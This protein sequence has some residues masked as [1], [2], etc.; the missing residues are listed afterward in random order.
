MFSGS[1]GRTTKYTDYEI[2]QT[3]HDCCDRARTYQVALFWAKSSQG[4]KGIH[5]QPRIYIFL[6]FK[7]KK[8]FV[9]YLRPHGLSS[10]LASRFFQSSGFERISELIVLSNLITV[11]VAPLRRS[12]HLTQQYTTCISRPPCYAASVVWCRAEPV[13][14]GPNQFCCAV[15][16]SCRS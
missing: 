2:H 3:E 13:S 7:K 5:P 10:G 4:L 1:N 6:L 11:W 8:F 9:L 15:S 14:Y 16:R 12:L